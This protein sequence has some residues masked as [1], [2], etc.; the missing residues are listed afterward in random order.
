MYNLCDVKL[1]DASAEWT[2][3]SFCC[4]EVLKMRDGRLTHLHL[5]VGVWIYGWICYRLSS[6]FDYWVLKFSFHYFYWIFHNFS[7][8]LRYFLYHGFP[9]LCF[10]K[11]GFANPSGKGTQVIGLT[12]KSSWGLPSLGMLPPSSQTSSKFWN[13]RS[14]WP[15]NKNKGK[16][17]VS[18][19]DNKMSRQICFISII[20]N[21]LK[22]YLERNLLWIQEFNVAKWSSTEESY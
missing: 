18:T 2:K 17:F 19:T 4:K 3:N 6:I 10:S 22:K 1:W 5:L 11:Q 14:N 15:K 21:K 16:I 12:G 8:L 13:Y 9:P 20:T 7:D